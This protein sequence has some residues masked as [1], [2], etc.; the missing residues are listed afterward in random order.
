MPDWRVNGQDLYLSG[1]KLKKMLFKNRAGKTDHEHCE[2]CFEKSPIIPIR[3]TAD[4]AP[5]MN[6][7]GYAKS[8]TLIS[9]GILSGKSSETKHRGIYLC[10][11]IY[12]I[13]ESGKSSLNMLSEKAII[14]V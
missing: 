4:I 9:K 8:V 11:W 14:S 7:I 6:I 2:F 1:V 12:T 13:I 5:K 3:F 10:G